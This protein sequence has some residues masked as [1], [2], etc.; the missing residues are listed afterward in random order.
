MFY[1]YRMPERN[2]ELL[3]PAGP[4]LPPVP[5][6]LTLALIGLGGFAAITLALLAG[7]WLPSL[8]QNLLDI[9]RGW[10]QNA[11]Q[12]TRVA[13]WISDINQFVLPLLSLALA[14]YWLWRRYMRAVTL[15]LVSGLGGELL[16]L[17]ILFAIG[18]PRPEKVVALAPIS[19]PGFPSGHAMAVFSLMGLLLYLFYKRIPS[20]FW[21][22]AAVLGLLVWGLLDGLT[23]LLLLA[24]HF[25]DI[26][27]GYLFGLGVLGLSIW[28]V[29]GHLFSERRE[30][31]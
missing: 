5:F 15:L 29:D 24:H 25:S 14:L 22:L 7:G 26:L 13:S 6:G 21:R 18:R 31:E 4:P 1:N 19:L 23:R 8:D 12:W 16:W 11:P 28:L 9:F 17:A 2:S 30:S 3:A 27:A 20:R 10:E